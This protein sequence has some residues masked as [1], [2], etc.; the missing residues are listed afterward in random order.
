MARAPAA[1]A[2]AHCGKQAMKIRY[3]TLDDIPASV[4]TGRRFHAMTRFAAY[5]YDA[6]R[7]ARNLRALI[8]LGANATRPH[9][10]FIV[11]DSD[12]QPAGILIGCIESHT[13]SAQ[14]V[15]SVIHYVVLPEK[16]M[17]GAGLRLL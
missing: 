1:E 4:E 10:F 2:G 3:A 15:A 5:D 11:E 17:S 8:E 9:C 16:R 12:G 14:P 6:E 7:V 13:F